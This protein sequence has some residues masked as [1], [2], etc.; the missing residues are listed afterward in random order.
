M[1][2]KTHHVIDNVQISNVVYNSS[3]YVVDQFAKEF[4]SLLLG[5]AGM[6]HTN[7]LFFLGN[8]MPMKIWQLIWL[9]GFYTTHPPSQN[10]F[11]RNWLYLDIDIEYIFSAITSRIKN[12]SARALSYK[13]IDLFQKT[14]MGIF[15][16]Q[17]DI[18]THISQSS[19]WTLNFPSPDI[20]LPNLGKK[21]K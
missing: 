5:C 9:V 10:F 4:L 13:F 17:E 1:H 15:W 14:R 20:Y 3:I 11:K 2:L 16:W 18:A 21:T 7:S 12:R 6:P 8:K 19:W